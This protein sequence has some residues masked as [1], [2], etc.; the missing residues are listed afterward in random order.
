MIVRG[1]V[2]VGKWGWEP[3]RLESVGQLQNRNESCNLLGVGESRGWCGG[4]G[5]RMQFCDTAD[6][7]SALRPAKAV[8]LVTGLKC[9]R[10]RSLLGGTPILKPR[11]VDGGFGRGPDRQTYKLWRGCGPRGQWIICRS[12]RLRLC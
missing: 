1:G 5:C 7:K 2:G 11:I 12:I 9:L 10:R 4:M 6:Y 3:V 8:L